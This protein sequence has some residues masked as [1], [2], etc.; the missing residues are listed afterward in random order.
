MISEYVFGGCSSM[1]FSIHHLPWSRRKPHPRVSCLKTLW[2]NSLRHWTY[3]ILTRSPQKRPLCWCPGQPRGNLSR[4]GGGKDHKYQYTYL[5]PNGHCELSSCS[6]GSCDWVDMKRKVRKVQM[7][8]S[9]IKIWI[10][11]FLVGCKSLEHDRID[12]DIA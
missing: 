1:T 2:R 11:E 3:A 7:W 6:G 12:K 9:M 4:S 10:S 8:C 5:Q